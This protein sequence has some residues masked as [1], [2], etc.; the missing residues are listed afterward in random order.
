VCLTEEKP[1]LAPVHQT[2]QLALKATNARLASSR[3][4]AV[5]SEERR[6]ADI[7][8][9]TITS[10]A[11]MR[12]RMSKECDFKNEMNML[13]KLIRE[14]GHLCLFLPKFHCDLN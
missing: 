2:P 9:K 13:Q 4:D 7:E 8:P 3:A 6:G 12:W 1:Q 5:E 14:R 10:L 11:W